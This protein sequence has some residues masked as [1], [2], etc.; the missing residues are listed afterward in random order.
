ME[1][2][3]DLFL[4]QLVQIR[5]GAQRSADCRRSFASFSG[6]LCSSA[7]LPVTSCQPL[8]VTMTEAAGGT[9]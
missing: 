2:A 5:R 7:G 1:T 3:D 6:V 8:C 9:A 4:L